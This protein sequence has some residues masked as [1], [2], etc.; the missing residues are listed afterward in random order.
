M[1]QIAQHLWMSAIAYT[2]WAN[3]LKGKKVNE[4]F[5]ENFI[6]AMVGV[7]FFI[8]M[9]L[10][11]LPLSTDSY[12]PT[13]LTCFMQ[14][15]DEVQTS[16]GISASVGWVFILF[17]PA[18]LSFLFSCLVLFKLRKLFSKHRTSLLND[19][20]ALMFQWPLLCLHIF[21]FIWYRFFC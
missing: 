16:A 9:I 13:G 6:S 8:P 7:C 5:T 11:I 19:S 20:K 4:L 18:L 2:M 10:A 12:G 1:F 17:V 15:D 3:M 14:M 21:I